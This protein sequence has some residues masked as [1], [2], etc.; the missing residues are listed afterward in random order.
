MSALSE[1]IRKAREV[2]VEAAGFSFTV[3]RPTDLEMIELRK[4]TIG[5]A[6]LPFV[7]GWGTVSELD[8]LGTGT[9]HPLDF[10]PVACADWLEDRVDILSAVVEAVFKSY[11]EHR[12]KLAES[13]KN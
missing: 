1:K 3:R 2:T 13:V 7:V 11:E 6:I 8:I 9:P 5:R 10:D 4:N 12:A